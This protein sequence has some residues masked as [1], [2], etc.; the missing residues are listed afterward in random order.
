MPDSGSKNTIPDL[1]SVEG[2][3]TLMGRI[4]KFSALAPS[5]LAVLAGQASVRSL[6]PGVEVYVDGTGAD[7]FAILVTGTITKRGLLNKRPIGSNSVIGTL[8]L[9]RRNERLRRRTASL[10]TLT[11]AILL[12]IPYRALDRLLPERRDAF[13][14]SVAEEALNLIEKLEHSDS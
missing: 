12:D 5:D 4:P 9:L 10:L 6:S 1:R 7:S 13:L 11:D 8:P 14:D 3:V 2:R